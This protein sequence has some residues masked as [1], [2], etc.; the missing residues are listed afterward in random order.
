MRSLLT[1][2]LLVAAVAP[3]LVL[4]GP[5]GYEKG[6]VISGEPDGQMEVNGLFYQYSPLEFAGWEWVGAYYTPQTGVCMVRST[7][8]LSNYDASGEQ[9]RLAADN[10]V[11]TLTKKYGAFEK[12]F[13]YLLP[14]SVLDEP[15]DW[16]TAISRGE[17]KYEY[18]NMDPLEDDLK[19]INVSVEHFGL[20]LN[21]R[22]NNFDA[23]EEA[24]SKAALSDL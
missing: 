18:Y 13:D 24:A 9:H 16:L 7:K 1:F 6:Q 10:L 21:Y 8:L 15:S 2:M 20:I 3:A 17:R 23:C 22:F 5:F 19:R 4:A 12:K 14:G 11:E